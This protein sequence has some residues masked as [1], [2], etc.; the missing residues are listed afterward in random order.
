MSDYIY[1]RNKHGDYLH[2][3]KQFIKLG[4]TSN[5]IRRD[6]QYATGEHIRGKYVKIFKLLNMDSKKCE[7]VLKNMFK[8]YNNHIDAGTEFYEYKIVELIEKTLNELHIDYI[9]IDINDIERQIKDNT[10]KRKLVESIPLLN[11]LFMKMKQEIYKP[12]LIAEGKREIIIRDYQQEGKDSAGEYYIENDKG[13]LNWVCGLGKTYESLYI[14]TDYFNSHLLIGIYRK[15]LASQWINA[16]LKFYKNY[17]ILLVGSF[18]K[19]EIEDELSQYISDKSIIKNVVDKITITTNVKIIKQWYDTYEKGI[20]I[21]M[22]ASS[23]K[24]KDIDI[25][26][27]FSILDECH[28]LSYWLDNIDTGDDKKRNTDILD[29]NVK[30][31]LSLTATMKKIDNENTIDNYNERYFGKI[32]DVKSLTWAIDKNYLCDYDIN[33]LKMNIDEIEDMISQYEDIPKDDYY[34]YLSAYISLLT[35]MENPDKKKLLIY[36]NRIEDTIKIKKYIELLIS[37]TSAFYELRDKLYREAI[38]CDTADKSKKIKEF[39]DSELGIIISVYI[40]GEGIDIPILD[41]VVFS[42][43]MTSRIRILQ[44]ASRPFRLNPSNLSK[45]ALLIIPTIFEDDDSSSY[46]VEEDDLKIKTFGKIMDVVSEMGTSD[47]NVMD[48]VKA[49]R[50]RK[51]EGTNE[52]KEKDYEIFDDIKFDREIKMRILA[53]GSLGKNTLPYLRKRIKSLG[54][55]IDYTLRC[56]EDYRKNKQHL[57]GLID[58]DIMKE[59]LQ[60]R[61][62]DWLSLYSVDTNKYIKWERFNI[63]W[64]N[65]NRDD[66]TDHLLT[67][68]TDGIYPNYSDLEDLYRVNGYNR[69]FWNTDNAE[70]F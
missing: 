68:N 49:I 9:I 12:K 3:D 23:N 50:I 47:K 61:N 20:T 32:I 22:Y 45:K 60:K 64:S 39:L 46:A 37:S 41:G 31:Q 65:K 24:L 55:R 2:Q 59:I 21:S 11:D 4:E 16:I 35:F 43:N 56:E 26:Y 44:S 53:R 19:T 70:E 29:L 54:G 62:S 28:H 34:Y 52:L 69:N 27:D 67:N 1:L 42:D 18:N 17:P 51:K 6:E 14:S 30:K 8:K 63:E 7:K 25:V 33:I 38:N 40:F 58:Y 48:K 57:P 66:Y 15:N 36:A 13:I 10:Y 5:L